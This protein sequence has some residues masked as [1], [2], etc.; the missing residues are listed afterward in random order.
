MR[1]LKGCVRETFRRGAAAINAAIERGLAMPAVGK[2]RT[3][4]TFQQ[5]RGDG[6]RRCHAAPPD[7]ARERAVPGESAHKRAG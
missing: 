7:Q 3:S 5:N 4:T 2:G 6:D 1:E